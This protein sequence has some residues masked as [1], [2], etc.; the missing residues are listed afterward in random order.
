MERIS[1]VLEIEEYVCIGKNLESVTE[2]I[3]VH[4]VDFSYKGTDVI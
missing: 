1:T 3:H 2:H 4:L